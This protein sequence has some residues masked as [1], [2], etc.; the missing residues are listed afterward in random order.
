MLGMGRRRTDA[1]G[2]R[3]WTTEGGVDVVALA[4]PSVPGGDRLVA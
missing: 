4:G 3:T 2:L 1:A